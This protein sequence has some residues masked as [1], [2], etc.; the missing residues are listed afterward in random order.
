M[1]KRL[2]S[3][4]ILSLKHMNLHMLQDGDIYVIIITM[5]EYMIHELRSINAI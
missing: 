4:T 5:S 3:C 2:V 1:I